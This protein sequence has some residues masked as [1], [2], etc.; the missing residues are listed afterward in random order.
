MYN[1]GITA[2]HNTA[3]Y[4]LG[5]VKFGTFS[6]FVYECGDVKLV[7]GK[8]FFLCISTDMVCY[9]VT[10]SSLIFLIK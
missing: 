8:K 6:G 7:V 2:I 1:L 10:Q 3:I 5:C 9:C 4:A